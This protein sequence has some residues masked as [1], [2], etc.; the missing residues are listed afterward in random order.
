MPITINLLTRE[1]QLSVIPDARGIAAEQTT[2]RAP[3]SPHIGSRKRRVGL[4]VSMLVAGII[5][6]Y[7]LIGYTLHALL[8]S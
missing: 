3:P 1:V 8:A 6:C 4:A 7:A 2:E 5:C